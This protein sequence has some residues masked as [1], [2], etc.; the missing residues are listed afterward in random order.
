MALSPIVTITSF[1]VKGGIAFKSQHKT[2]AFVPFL[3]IS[4][5]PDTAIDEY[6]RYAQIRQPD[7]ATTM[8]SSGNMQH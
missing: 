4:R 3:I 2:W 7:K 5:V 1:S 8:D 6:L